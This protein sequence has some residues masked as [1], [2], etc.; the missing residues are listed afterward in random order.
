MTKTRIR[1]EI[2]SKLN[3][4][5]DTQRLRKSRLIKLKLFKLAE[6][7]RARYVMFYAATKQEVETRFMIAAAQKIGKKIMVPTVLQG[8]KRM[9][10]SFIEDIETETYPGPYGIAQ[11]KKEYIREVPGE[12][13]DLVV[14]PGLAFAKTGKRLGRGGGYYDK[15]LAGLP[16]RIPRIGLAFD[17]QVLKD[18]PALSHDIS[19]TKVISA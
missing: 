18:L 13:I 5:S 8:K 7:K 3:K 19:V 6:F 10:A 15:F 9:I 17:F 4:Q 11:P 2:K 12:L 14:V 1:K 16:T